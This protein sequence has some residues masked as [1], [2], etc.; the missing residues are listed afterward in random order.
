MT[1][2]NQAPTTQNYDVWASSLDKQR[3]VTF[4]TSF[5][6]VCWPFCDNFLITWQGQTCQILQQISS[7]IVIKV[8]RFWRLSW[9][10]F[11]DFLSTRR[12]KTTTFGH[13][14]LTSQNLLKWQF[15]DE[16]WTRQ[17]FV[18]T[19]SAMATSSSDGI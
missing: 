16:S 17:Y 5:W 2:L 9:Q 7:K 14:H 6:Q 10:D 13:R 1:T 18:C 3:L 11:E 12:G 19:S 15:I 8:T 4:L